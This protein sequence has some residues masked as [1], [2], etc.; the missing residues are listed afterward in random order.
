[1]STQ[2]HDAVYCYECQAYTRG[3]TKIVGKFQLCS[4]DECGHIEKYERLESDD[5]VSD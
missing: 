2:E 4:C 3:T 1:M 5:D